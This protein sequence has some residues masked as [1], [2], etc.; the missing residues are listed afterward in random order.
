MNLDFKKYIRSRLDNPRLVSD[1]EKDL[2]YAADFFDLSGKLKLV[3][4]RA[5]NLVVYDCNIS[6][7]SNPSRI[8]ILSIGEEVAHGFGAILYTDEVL[9][10]QRDSLFSLNPSTGHWMFDSYFLQY[11]QLDSILHALSDEVKQVGI[12][13][14]DK[15]VV[16]DKDMCHIPLRYT[17]QTLASK[18]CFLPGRGSEVNSGKRVGIS[19]ETGK[20]PTGV[21]APLDTLTRLM[22]NGKEIYVP[23]HSSTLNAPFYGNF[24]WAHVLG[25][26]AGRS[27]SDV[28]I[29]SVPCRLVRI[30]PIVDAYGDVFV[31]VHSVVDGKSRVC[32][33]AGPGLEVERTSVNQEYQL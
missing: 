27:S 31:T 32:L 33:I 23:L 28:V 20:S 24:T 17:L 25:K 11:C 16:V 2:I 4:V 13:S 8:S 1:A 15:L 18:V 10:K 14:M 30:T 3:Y 29:Q 12:S 5:K 21:S 26:L 19:D 7:D 6:K 9:R 22:Q